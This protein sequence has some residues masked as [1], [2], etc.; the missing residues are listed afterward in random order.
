[1]SDLTIKIIMYSLFFI[2]IVIGIVN[3]SIDKKDY[4]D[5]KKS[6]KE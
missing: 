2:V 4:K 5:W 6:L 3:L 1:M